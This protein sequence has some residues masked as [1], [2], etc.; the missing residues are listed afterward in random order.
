MM[1]RAY[2]WSLS[3][4]IAIA[5]LTFSNLLAIGAQ[6]S[7][8]TYENPLAYVGADNG[9]YI[10]SLDG[11]RTTLIA[12]AT[13]TTYENIPNLYGAPHWSLQGT[14]LAFVDQKFLEYKAKLYRVDSG[15]SP[16]ALITST[17]LEDRA[18]AWSPDGK[19]IAYVEGPPTSDGLQLHVVQ[20]DGS[21][22]RVFAPLDPGWIADGGNPEDVSRIVAEELDQIF[23]TGTYSLDWTDQGLLASMGGDGPTTLFSL[24][25]KV[26]WQDH[27]NMGKMV[28]SPDRTRAIFGDYV[29]DQS[30][31]SYKMK[32]VMIDLA[33]GHE[34][35]FSIPI[36][37][38]P[39]AWTGD[40]KS[41]IYSTSTVLHQNPDP[42]F[43][44]Q[45]HEDFMLTLWR[46]GLNETKL[47]QYRGYDIG[48]VVV[49]PDNKTV[50]F[51]LIVNNALDKLNPPV[52]LVAVPLNG[53]QA[54]WIA[55]GGKPAFGKGPFT[56][57][58]AAPAN[59]VQPQK[60]PKSL[61]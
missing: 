24:D 53:G 18:L 57:V 15:K 38:E 16:N 59:P 5:A 25:G 60:C 58:L 47:F 36:G 8:V 9:L 3:L 14:Q 32:P 31:Q 55:V 21:K 28:V 10:T 52:Q 27:W 44:D 13:P 23:Y 56:A 12:S 41:I 2:L 48:T 43:P 26:I 45:I 1:Q 42:A 19:Q 49:S 50:V 20:S 39:L 33:N 54:N 17:Q 6:P 40:G 30:D 29:Y 4:F 34:L 11:I 22:D 37:S 51:S 46:Q 35:P 7:P 61:P